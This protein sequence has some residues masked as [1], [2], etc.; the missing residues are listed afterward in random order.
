MIYLFDMPE[1]AIARLCLYAD[2]LYPEVR[3]EPR[4]AVRLTTQ[5]KRQVT[6]I[7]SKLLDQEKRYEISYK[8]CINRYKEHAYQL[9]G[10]GDVSML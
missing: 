8:V 3:C 7:I 6:S 2:T 4:M 10:T 1:D 9:L 5:H